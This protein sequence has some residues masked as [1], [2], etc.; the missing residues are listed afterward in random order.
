ML[1]IILFNI[2]RSK[3]AYLKEF[4][5]EIMIRH[6]HNHLINSADTLRHRTPTKQVEEIFE[7]LF[8][9]GHSPSTA[10]EIY[11]MDLQQEYGEDYHLKV[12]DGSLCPT[13]RWCYE[14][15]YKL[16][17]RE[18]GEPTGL[19][20]LQSLTKF[21]EDYNKEKGDSCAAIWS[22]ENDLVIALCSPI[23]KR[24]HKYLKSSGEIVFLDSSGN[25]DR[26][27]SRVFILFCA[28]TAGALPLG[29]FITFSESE[30]MILQGL[31]LLKSILPKESF[32]GRQQPNIVITDDCA[33]E[34]NSLRIAFPKSKLLLCQFHVLQ[35]F[36]RYVWCAKNGVI[37]D[38]RTYVFQIFRKLLHLKSI[39]EFEKS[40]SAALEDKTLLLYD[41]IIK[42]LK[43][44]KVRASEWALCHRSHLLTRGNNTNN[45]CEAGFRILKDK[46][47]NRTK[48]FSVVQMFS[49]LTN[50]YENYYKRKLTDVINN[51]MEGLT[52]MKYFISEQRMSGLKCERFSEDLF[53]VTNGDKKYT[54]NVELEVCTCPI[55][56]QGAPCKHQCAVVKTFKL[57]S[58]LFV[59]TTDVL[60]KMTFHKILTGSEDLSQG[61]YDTL[62]NEKAPVHSFNNFWA[63]TNLDTENSDLSAEQ[64][65]IVS[66]CAFDIPGIHKK[67][68]DFSNDLKKLASQRPDSF[69]PALE[70]FMS[71]Y[72]SLKTESALVSAMHSFGKYT[73]TASALTVKKKL[74][75]GKT[76]GVQPTAVARRKVALGGRHCSITGRPSKALSLNS[77]HSYSLLKRKS[78]FEVPHS[79]KNKIPHSISSISQD[80]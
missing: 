4:P 46:I 19:E 56:Q 10:F 61:W 8:S 50:S 21:V 60:Q 58:S 65:E 64:P 28:S 75:G 35:A 49:F 47:L 55:G 62:S 6:T 39:D 5:T 38:D 33:A 34:R 73:G 7:K 74:N 32:N 77:E 72:G 23:M 41:K 36:M 16:F 15:Y 30:C 13:R 14:L 11:K 26:H 37:S 9:K 80:R 53:V 31:Q 76:I 40:F 45:Y 63:P 70:A 78:A 29:V 1:I 71:N 52:K 3:D 42:Y 18:Y 20:M 48:A 67:I 44:M 54:V 66:N 69:G 22:E 79:K 25:M 57:S 2:F 43:D 24:V 68:D 27:N 17:K 59:P 51:R 12:A